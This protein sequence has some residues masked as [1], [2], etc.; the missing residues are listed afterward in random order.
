MFAGEEAVAFAL[1]FDTENRC[2]VARRVKAVAAERPRIVLPGVLDHQAGPDF[3]E[4][5]R[6]RRRVAHH[7]G[8][9][10]NGIGLAGIDGPRAAG[11]E[12]E[13]A[14][15]AR[16]PPAHFPGRLEGL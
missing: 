10:G 9:E 7:R 13:D 14:P 8:S 4:P 12:V 3:A 11:E 2:L 6:D 15:R 16:L 1:A 5:R